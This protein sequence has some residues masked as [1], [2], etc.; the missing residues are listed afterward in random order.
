MIDYLP[1]LRSEEE[2]RKNLRNIAWHNIA[3]GT[4]WQ[5]GLTVFVQW[6]RRW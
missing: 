6:W 3:R 4:T 5:A 1:S 2:I